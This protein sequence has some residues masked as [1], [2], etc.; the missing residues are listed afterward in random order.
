MLSLGT[1]L[2]VESA[3]RCCLKVEYINPEKEPPKDFFNSP[4]WC[5]GFTRNYEDSSEFV[6][7]L[8]ENYI[9]VD[10]S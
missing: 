3:L 10:C 2:E 9:V 7:L 1:D 8:I 6:F 4:S 5:S